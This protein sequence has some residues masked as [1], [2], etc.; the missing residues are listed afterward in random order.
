PDLLRPRRNRRMLA[1]GLALVLLAIVPYYTPRVQRGGWVAAVP[2][3]ALILGLPWWPDSAIT[4]GGGNTD[5]WSLLSRIEEEAVHAWQLRLLRSRADAGS[6]G[7][8]ARIGMELE[9]EAMLQR[10]VKE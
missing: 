2:T 10:A 5:D 3:T 6:A 9:D 8:L 4:G 1:A 7:K